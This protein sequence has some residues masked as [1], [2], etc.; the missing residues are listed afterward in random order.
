MVL[1]ALRRMRVTKQEASSKQHGRVKGTCQRFGSRGIMQKQQ[2]VQAR[3]GSF[4]RGSSGWKIEESVEGTTS[5]DAA[6]G[7][8][9]EIDVGPWRY[10]PRQ[11]RDDHGEGRGR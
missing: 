10:D 7:P 8:S 4:R 11:K 3:Q 2:E 1:V 5:R 9:G 6:D